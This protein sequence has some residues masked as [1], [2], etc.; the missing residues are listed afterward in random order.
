MKWA[1]LPLSSHQIDML[2]VQNTVLGCFFQS[3]NFIGSTIFPYPRGLVIWPSGQASTTGWKGDASF[4]WDR[5]ERAEWSLQPVAAFRGSGVSFKLFG[6]PKHR[7]CRPAQQ[8]W[9][10][11]QVRQLLSDS[12]ENI[13]LVRVCFWNFWQI[14]SRRLGLRGAYSVQSGVVAELLLSN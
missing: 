14:W 5:C 1:R 9:R 4:E 12:G 7:L 3:M 8:Q 6:G 11:R 2:Q 10:K 13:E